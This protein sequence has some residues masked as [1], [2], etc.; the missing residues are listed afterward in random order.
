MQREAFRNKLIVFE[1]F[2]LAM[3][4]RCEEVL[5]DYDCDRFAVAGDVGVL[6]GPVGPLRLDERTIEIR[7]HPTVIK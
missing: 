7:D 4:E 6:V 1:I 2:I 5:A 3:E